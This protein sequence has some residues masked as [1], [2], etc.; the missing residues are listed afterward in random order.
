MKRVV[1]FVALMVAVLSCGSAGY[2]DDSALPPFDPYHV[3]GIDYPHLMTFLKPGNGSIEG[4][5]TAKTKVFGLIAFPN[6]RVDLLPATNLSYW[7]LRAGGYA[8]SHDNYK[9]PMPNLPNQLAPYLKYMMTDANGYFRFDHLAD[10]TY[11]VYANLLK[12]EFQNPTRYTTEAQTADNGDTVTT[13]KKY[14]GLKELADA[15][16]IA[17][18]V[19][20][21][22]KH[23][24][25]TV[26]A[27]DVLGEYTCCKA[28]L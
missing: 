9:G 7:V 22:S 16:V 13:L 24:A 2:S 19:N 10:G 1:G 14:Q 15:L 11:Y 12:R 5:L 4:R 8:V 17:A 28:E 20:I 23:P 18:G 27:F 21:D 26:T 25:W 6:T 3:P